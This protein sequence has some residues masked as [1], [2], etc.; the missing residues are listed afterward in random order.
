MLLEAD[1]P[2]T[3]PPTSQDAWF[4]AQ[5]EDGQWPEGPQTPPGEGTT[6]PD[7]LIPDAPDGRLRCRSDF[8][9]LYDRGRSLRGEGMVLIFGPN[10][11]TETR[12]GFVASRK[13][14]A[15][16]VRNRMKRLL[17]EAY[18]QIR[19]TI[20]L[21]GLDLV[22]IARSGL[23]GAKIGDAVEELTALCKR[24]GLW[25]GGSPPVEGPGRS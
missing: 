21:E 9:R 16:V 2:A 6:S 13:V 12:R 7:R 19:P 11:R 18:R 22:L 15:A 3:Q 8:Q 10:G 20:R 23:R 1:V 25:S 5:D 4:P 14:G 24:A 17:R